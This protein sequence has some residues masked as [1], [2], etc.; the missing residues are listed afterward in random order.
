LTFPA[1]CANAVI[2]TSGHI[3]T[4]ALLKIPRRKFLR[5]AGAAAI[6][7][8]IS[9]VATAQAYPARPITM[10]VPFAAGGIVD[11]TG[12]ILVDRMRKS[13]GQSIIVENVSGADGNI[14]TGRGA[15]AR[16]DGY[17]MNFGTISTHVLS[18][19]FYSL[20]YDVLNDFA[21]ISPVA[22]FPYFLYAR[23]T[24]AAKDLNEL[25]AWLKANPDKASAG[26][27]AAS[28]HLLTAFFQKEKGTQFA[29]VPYRGGATA[30]QDLVA[31]QIDL[32]FGTPDYL[33]LVRSGSIKAYA[34]T[35]DTRLALAPDIPTFA[36][37]GMP[38][39][40][41]SAWGGLFAPQGTPREII[42]KLNEAAVEALA[43]PVLRDRL[44]DLGLK[45]FSRERQTPEALAAL[46]KADAE[47]WWPIIKE[48]GIKAE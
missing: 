36:E 21:P 14:G 20:E 25:M 26:T 1:G 39:L 10:I 28:M 31:G 5:F 9:H 33:S 18:G 4:A 45:I 38:V 17:T 22:A 16:P 46:Q 24:M 11:V 40:S 41:Y 34:V 12:R 27:V 15:R 7:P 13:L 2:N 44:A 30:V 23:K 37:L 19:A 32:F 6:A 48:F 47:K 8:A 35:S 3:L 42:A 29:L 43:D